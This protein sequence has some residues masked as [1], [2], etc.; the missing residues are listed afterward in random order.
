[1]LLFIPHFLG[2][3]LVLAT[4]VVVFVISNCPFSYIWKTLSNQVKSWM[5][6]P[7]NQTSKLEGLGLSSLNL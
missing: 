4:V 1:M 5:F 2:I 6:F 3:P 7:V